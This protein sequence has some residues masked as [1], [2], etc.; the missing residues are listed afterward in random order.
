M[1]QILKSF[2]SVMSVCVC[3]SVCPLTY[4]R[5]FHSI[6]MKLCTIVWNQ[7]SKI[8]FLMGQ[9][10]ITPFHISPRNAFSTGMTEQSR[11]ESGGLV[12]AF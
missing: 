5:N 7:I 4:G 8:E 12:V 9:N 6:Y 11:N 3:M 2:T 10:P 1:G